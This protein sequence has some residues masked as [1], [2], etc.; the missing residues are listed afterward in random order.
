[1][2]VGSV[3]CLRAA[4]CMPVTLMRSMHMLVNNTLSLSL[5]LFLRL[6]GTL[7]HSAVTCVDV[8]F[9]G[10]I[11]QWRL[12]AGSFLTRRIDLSYFWSN[13]CFINSVTQAVCCSLACV[14]PPYFIYP[15]ILSILKF[16]LSFN[17]FIAALSIWVTHSLIGDSCFH[18]VVTLSKVL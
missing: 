1:M 17:R 2:F 14:H 11:P 9:T 12:T 8:L 6:V 13:S 18:S 7:S 16:L 4:T 3:R 10:T 15:V 5:L